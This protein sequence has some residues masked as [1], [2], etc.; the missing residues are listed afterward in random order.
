MTENREQEPLLDSLAKPLPDAPPWWSRKVPQTYVQWLRASAS[1]LTGRDL[2]AF[3]EEQKWLSDNRKRARELAACVGKRMQLKADRECWDENEQY[4]AGTVFQI[5]DHCGPYLHGFTN[6]R[7]T[8]IV[9]L[10]P[11]WLEPA[12]AMKRRSARPRRI[13]IRNRFAL[14]Q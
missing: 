3:E 2:K 6:G 1:T 4:K 5:T 11:E 14:S 10:R 8:V 7:D 13:R 12:T 9:A